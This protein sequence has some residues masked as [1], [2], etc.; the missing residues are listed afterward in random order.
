MY[1]KSGVAETV[2]KEYNLSTFCVHCV[3]LS[4]FP[5]SFFY[6]PNGPFTHTSTFMLD[7]WICYIYKAL[8]GETGFQLASVN[9]ARSLTT[10]KRVVYGS[11]TESLRLNINSCRW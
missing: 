9:G 10:Y 6:I 8:R 5:S 3:V 2:H 11:H 1:I 4:V 7:Y